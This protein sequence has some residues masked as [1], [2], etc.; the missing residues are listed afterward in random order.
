[1]SD[2]NM[3]DNNVNPNMN[4]DIEDISKLI[5]LLKSSGINEI[6]VTQGETGIRLRKDSA[7]QP[8]QTPMQAPVQT[9][10]QTPAHAPAHSQA[11]P[12]EAAQDGK[13]NPVDGHVM[14]APM[15]GTF[16][17]SPSPETNPYVKVGDRVSKGQ[18]ICIIEAMKT[19]NQ[20]EAEEDGTLQN[21]LV[22]DAQAVEF[23]EP[24]FVIQ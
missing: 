3:R 16:Y 8:I 10:A 20:I 15:V 4:V 21:I 9:P 1:M 23:G 13:N 14:T 12:S 18:T 17:Q 5:D 19:M 2:N 24:L 11:R 7:P 6:E 22:N